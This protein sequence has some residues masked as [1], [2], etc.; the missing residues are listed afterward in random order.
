MNIEP[1]AV[2]SMAWLLLGESLGPLQIVGGVIVAVSPEHP[3]YLI[4]T[5]KC[6]CVPFTVT[7]QDV[8]EGRYKR[9]TSEDMG[10]EL[11]RGN[12]TV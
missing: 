11:V 3:P 2:A 5:K 10:W 8:D 6:L 12:P 1:V 4:D 9:V 7:Q